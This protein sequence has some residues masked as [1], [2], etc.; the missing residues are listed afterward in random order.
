MKTRITM[1]A[2]VSMFLFLWMGGSAFASYPHGDFS[3]SPDVCA[4]CHRMH[5]ATALNLIKDPSG[6]GLCKTCHSAALGADTDVMNGIYTEGKDTAPAHA[7]WGVDGDKLLGG[8]FTY[9]QNT[10]TTTSKH[11]VDET[12]VPPGAETGA[13]IQFRCTSCHNAHPDR[14][15][16]NQYRLLRVRPNGVAADIDV[17]WN[18]PWDDAGATTPAAD[19]SDLTK[20][21]AYTEIE[22]GTGINSQPLQAGNPIE[23]TRNYVDADMATWCAACHTHYMATW[24]PGAP[25]TA[26]AYKTGDVYDAGD[27]YGDVARDRHSV[28]TPIVNRTAI[29]DVTYNLKTDVPLADLTA[30][31]RTNDDLLTCLSCHKAHGSDALMANES[32]LEDRG[33]VLPSGVDSM[34]LRGDRGRRICADCHNI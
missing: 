5:T 8:G 26:N 13:S 3:S 15:H 21:R 2:V 24:T 10:S 33:A 17:A 31:G 14:N 16:P 11:R 30:N 29:N 6:G 27:D 9:I 19:K 18:G 22:Y 32:I 20:N 4:A 1:L 25:G 23:Y 34:L 28:N 12:L 7:E